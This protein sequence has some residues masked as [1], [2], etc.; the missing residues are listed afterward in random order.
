MLVK[1]LVLTALVSSTPIAILVTQDPDRRPQP[2]DAP[3][4]LG[5]A[6]LAHA[7]A[8]LAQAHAELLQVRAQLEQAL[9][10][11][12][13]SCEPRRDHGSCSPSRSRA[14]MSHYQWL[15]EQGHATRAAGT[16]AKVVDQFGEEPNRLNG[17]A[18]NLMTDKETAGKH[19]EVAL[20][21][22]QR[23]GAHADQLQ[24]HHLDT[25]ALAH[26]LNGGI[27]RAV[28]LQQQ[29][30]ERGG[31]GDDYR[32]RLR[33]YEAARAAVAARQQIAATDDRLIAAR[34]D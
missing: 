8:E 16:L 11:L 27:E 15:R 3:S 4:R 1:A 7:R 20:A 5:A 2:A 12:D 33:T 34:D 10:A 24:A 23:M 32:R 31:N 25:M 30:I 29:A 9:D 14:L 21:I 22:A 19:D 17:I 26:F 13:R 28:E 18:W 6:E